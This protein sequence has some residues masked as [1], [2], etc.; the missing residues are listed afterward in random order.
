MK[1]RAVDKAKAVVIDSLYP[2]KTLHIDQGYPST[3]H[4]QIVQG[5]EKTA[6]G[7]TAR[8]AF[9]SR[10]RIARISGYA[11]GERRPHTLQLSPR[12]H[13]Y[14]AWF[15]GLLQHSCNPNVFLD[16]TYLELWTVQPIAA[17]TALT[18]DYSMT[19]DTLFRQLACHC[20]ELNCRG[21]ITGSKEPLNAEGQAFMAWWCEHKR[22]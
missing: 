22:S 13:L 11:V 20:G 7:I 10:V 15:C 6:A 18:L 2:F 3:E 9:D 1:T 12:I 5:T 16:T 21:W 8:V 4:F 19:E 14:D 17:G